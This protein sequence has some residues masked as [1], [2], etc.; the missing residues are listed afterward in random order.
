MFTCANCALQARSAPA[1]WA[2]KPHCGKSGVP[3]MYSTTGA[4]LS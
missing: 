1:V 2:E 3:F 4:E